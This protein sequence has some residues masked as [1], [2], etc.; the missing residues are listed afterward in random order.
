MLR[1]PSSVETIA[2]TAIAGGVERREN[3]STGRNANHMN[4]HTGLSPLPN[5]VSVA[6]H[7]I[8]S[9]ATTACCVLFADAIHIPLKRPAAVFSELLFRHRYAP[10][11]IEHDQPLEERAHF[12]DDLPDIVF[13]Q[14]S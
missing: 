12:E 1:P 9:A 5:Q 7:A 14:N 2:T 6:A 3:H 10:A 11:E 4:G 8:T 13:S